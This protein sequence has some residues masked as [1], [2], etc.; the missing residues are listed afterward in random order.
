MDAEALRRQIAA[1]QQ[2]IVQTGSEE[3]K[4]RLRGSV[5]SLGKLLRHAERQAKE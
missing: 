5:R 2:R 4:R 1:L 3:T